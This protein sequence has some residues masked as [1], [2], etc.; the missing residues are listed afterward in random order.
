M[1]RSAGYSTMAILRMLTQFDRGDTTDLRRALDTPEPGE[2]IYYATDQWLTTLHQQEKNAH[3]L[4]MMLEERI[5]K[6]E[7]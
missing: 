1:L 7:G 2:D 4:M 6:G 3:N 5:R